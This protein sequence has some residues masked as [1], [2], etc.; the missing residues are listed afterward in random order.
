MTLSRITKST[1]EKQ[2]YYTIFKGALPVL[3]ASQGIDR[4]QSACP[5]GRRPAKDHTNRK[6][7]E[8]KFPLLA[9][10][11]GIAHNGKTPL[12]SVA[13]ISEYGSRLKARAK[14]HLTGSC[15]AIDR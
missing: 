6:G 10:G 7:E 11:I 4:I 3:L 9:I 5:S 2:D 1:S 13:Q 14:E 8:E 12:T 15:Y